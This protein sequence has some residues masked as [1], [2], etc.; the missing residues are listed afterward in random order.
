MLPWLAMR[1]RRLYWLS[2]A[3]NGALC[4]AV[5][6]IS[7]APDW[8]VNPSGRPYLQRHLGRAALPQAVLALAETQG[9]GAIVSR[10]RSLLANLTYEARDSD[11]AVFSVPSDG[12]PANYYQQTFP[13]TA[14]AA[15]VVLYVTGS[16]DPLCP[17]DDV[18][19]I[20]T[21]GTAWARDGGRLFGH[22]LPAECHGVLSDP[23][24][25]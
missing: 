19:E 12:H 17:Q 4:L 23:G 5:P 24:T 20:D 2:L 7:L 11:I 10:G 16:G 9:A 21:E 14:G 18:T 22:R 8:P 15:E 25:P 6:L 13:W 1:A 3:L